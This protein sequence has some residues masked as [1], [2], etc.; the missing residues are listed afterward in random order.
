MLL[1]QAFGELLPALAAV[2]G[3]VDDH[4]RVA[5]IAALRTVLR[6]HVKSLLFFLVNGDGKAESRRQTF[7]DV[8]PLLATVASLVHAAV[9]L[10]EDKSW[11]RGTQSHGVQALAHFG[12]LVSLEVGKHAFVH[13]TPRASIIVR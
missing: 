13:R 9:V 2:L 3:F 12:E 4:L 6:N 1:R 8:F 11:L 7:V 5:N 10:L